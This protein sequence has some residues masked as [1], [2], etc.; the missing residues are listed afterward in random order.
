MPLRYPQSKSEQVVFRDN[1]FNSTYTEG[2]QGVLS[3]AP[4]YS[5][6]LVLNGTDQYVTYDIAGFYAKT[7]LTFELWFTPDFDYDYDAE[8]AF[9]S[10]SSNDYYLRKNNNAANNT[11]SIDVGN[12]AVAT[13]PSASYSAHWNV[14]V[15]NHIVVASTSG[16][17]D[18]YLNG[19]LILDADASAWNPRE[20]N[21]IH[22]GADDTPLGFFDGTIHSFSILA[23]HATAAEVADMYIQRTFKKTDALEALVSLPLKSHYD[24]AGVEKT[25][26]LGT[27]GDVLWGNGATAATMPE[28][29]TPHGFRSVSNDYVTCTSGVCDG[30]SAITVSFVIKVNT[31]S[32]GNVRPFTIRED[33]GASGFA[34]YSPGGDTYWMLWNAGGANADTGVLRDRSTQH[35]IMVGN[36]IG[37]GVG[38]ANIYFYLNGE[39]ANQS[40]GTT[41]N[42]LGGD[43][44]FGYTTGLEGDYFFPRIFGFELTPVQIRELH[45]RD[46]RRLNS[47]S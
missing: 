24:D 31:L 16:S 38:N 47:A 5:N 42:N 30:L 19:N 23:F 21:N 14:G 4:T 33:G 17:T 2:L 36:G 32:Q 45:D 29:V 43:C 10:T 25:L 15:K 40:T 39:L 26:N 7:E 9:F 3:G 22:I 41:L 6:G 27:G 11:I 44:L 37:A 1:M 34:V 20:I 13:I 35:I 8:V 28:Q 12:V 18:V 46:M